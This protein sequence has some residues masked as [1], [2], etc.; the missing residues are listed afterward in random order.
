MVSTRIL[1]GARLS[2]DALDVTLQVT[3][4]LVL[5]SSGDLCSLQSAQAWL[6]LWAKSYL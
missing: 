4:K 5:I 2:L 6:S 1:T 3:G